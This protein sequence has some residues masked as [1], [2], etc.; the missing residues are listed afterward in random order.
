VAGFLLLA[1]SVSF[2][3]FIDQL[4]LQIDCWALASL[5]CNLKFD[6]SAL[7]PTSN[8]WQWAAVLSLPAALILI[9]LLNNMR[10]TERILRLI[11]VQDLKSTALGRIA[12]ESLKKQPSMPIAINLENNHVIIRHPLSLDSFANSSSDVDVLPFASGYRDEKQKL[13]L[14]TSYHWIYELPETEQEVFVKAISRSRIVSAN[15]FDEEKWLNFG[16]SDA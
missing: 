3:I 14:R 11:L 10:L 13:N 7:E 15:L 4:W 6:I 16:R 1:I 2:L 8:Q 9:V 12:L 5:P